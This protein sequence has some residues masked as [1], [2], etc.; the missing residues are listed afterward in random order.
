VQGGLSRPAAA[1]TS[2]QPAAELS[3][4]IPDDVLQARVEA[5]LY[6]SK[7]LDTADIAVTASNGTV[8]LTGTVDTDQLK[9]YAE[10]LVRQIKGVRRIENQIVVSGG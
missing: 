7:Q 4:T 2:A 6:R 10:T 5:V 1:P 3:E 9:K 8:K